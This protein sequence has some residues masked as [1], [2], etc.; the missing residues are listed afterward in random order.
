MLI[1]ETNWKQELAKLKARRVVLRQEYDELEKLWHNGD[2]SS[3]LAERAGDIDIEIDDVLDKAIET[4]ENVFVYK[5][6]YI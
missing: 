1:D 6:C 5:R 2:R 4:I 3:A